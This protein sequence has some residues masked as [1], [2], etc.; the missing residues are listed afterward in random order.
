MSKVRNTIP[1]KIKAPHGM[2]K[3][4]AV[5]PVAAEYTKV[6]SGASGMTN[7]QL[8]PPATPQR[9]KF[10]TV[11]SPA[12]AIR[13]SRVAQPPPPSRSPPAREVQAAATGSEEKPLVSPLAEPKKAA[14]GA[15]QVKV[16]FP[17]PFMTLDSKGE[18]LEEMKRAPPALQETVEKVKKSGD[19]GDFVLLG[20]GNGPN[21]GGKGQ[22]LELK[23]VRD[24]AGAEVEYG[25]SRRCAPASKK[26]S[27]EP[28]PAP[29]APYCQRAEGG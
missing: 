21:A 1:K 22:Q 10:I 26:G 6:A 14:F 15:A 4:A 16:N 8:R 11:R 13:P 27:R 3:T 25:G 18:L 2:S 20:W 5:K 7:K 29:H 23:E 19:E 28:R 12:R 17:G 9:K 24:I